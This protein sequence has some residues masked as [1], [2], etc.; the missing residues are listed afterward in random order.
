MHSKPHLT[1]A[2][3]ILIVSI[4]QMS[5]EPVRR[6]YYR[7]PAVHGESI[8]FTAEGDLWSASI[9]G[10]AAQRLTTSPGMERFASISP[11]GKM[12]AFQANY[13][14]P[15]EVYTMPTGGTWW[16]CATAS[17]ARTERHSRKGSES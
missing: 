8:V 3:A 1:A 11:D 10:G 16:F 6:G 7:F 13:E 9:H 15:D 2:L 4:G 14:G 12:V 17:P 5:A